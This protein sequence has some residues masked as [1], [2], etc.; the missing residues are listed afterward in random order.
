MDAFTGKNQLIDEEKKI[1]TANFS[2]RRNDQSEEKH[3]NG[4][5]ANHK[6][7]DWTNKIYPQKICEKVFCVQFRRSFGTKLP[8][9]SKSEEIKI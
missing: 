8:K 7:K 4:K 9:E 5:V 6:E 3:S 2:S 1:E